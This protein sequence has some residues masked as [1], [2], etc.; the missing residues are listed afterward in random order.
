MIYNKLNVRDYLV[1]ND[2]IKMANDLMSDIGL[3]PLKNYIAKTNGTNIYD[4]NLNIVKFISDFILPYKT[5]AISKYCNY[6]GITLEC[7]FKDL[8]FVIVM[9]DYGKMNPFWQKYIKQIMNGNYLYTSHIRHEFNAFIVIYE[10][11]KKINPVTTFYDITHVL[12]PIFAHHGNL[13]ENFIKK[14]DFNGNFPKTPEC[15]NPLNENEFLNCIK[16]ISAKFELKENQ[17]WL[18]DWYRQEIFRYILSEGDKKSSSY[19]SNKRIL[20]PFNESFSFNDIFQGKYKNFQTEVL[21][22]ANNDV[23][24]VRAKTGGGKTFASLLWG[25]Y[26]IGNGYAERIVIAMPTQ[27]TSNSI[28][29][30]C[31]EFISDTNVYHGDVKNNLDSKF[32]RYFFLRHCMHLESSLTVLTIDQ[33]LYAITLYNDEY[34]TVA[35]NLAN[36]CLIIDEMDFYDSFVISNVIELIKFCRRFNVRI[37]IM[38]ATI[39]DKLINIIKDETNISYKLIDFSKGDYTPKTDIISISNWNDNIYDI[40]KNANNCIIYCNTIKSAIENYD[41]IKS[42]RND[43]VVYHSNM[44]S[45]DKINREK[46]IVSMLGKKA[47]NDKNAKGVVIMTQIGELSINISSDIIISE[48]APIDR[49]IQRFG[50]GCRF[51]EDICKAYIILPLND[52]NGGINYFPYV[53]KNGKDYIPN[54]YIS[55]TFD[56]LC[57]KTY[58]YGTFMEMINEIYLDFK[59]EE[60]DKFNSNKICEISKRNIFLNG[61]FNYEDIEDGFSMPLDWKSRDI[62]PN[63]RIYINDDAF[64]NHETN[65]SFNEF[66]VLKS[67]YSLTIRLKNYEK[68][69]K[70]IIH[71]EIV[72]EHKKFYIEI[73]PN[74]YY[75][76]TENNFKGLNI[77]YLIECCRTSAVFL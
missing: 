73:L 52:Y 24:F 29:I 2:L 23:I 70:L 57:E 10:K 77:N 1:S 71:K 34:K 11:Y 13:N 12:F 31:S 26:Q 75:F 20:M 42:F 33:L 7:F 54:K 25:N 30:D 40:V 64:L 28:S 38:S 59:I 46:K 65:Y 15:K 69:K 53:V 9:H 60:Y 49:L 43:V 14:Y 32:D 16:K 37:L 61:C 66:M 35:F 5:Y 27:F 67:K 50:R 39:P 17:S 51:N 18:N 4:H 68:I 3:L 41:I 48:L 45:E 55:R 62:E 63:I 47:W 22:Q 44:L 8:L 19:E 76:N 6:F 56:K 72:V 21:K 74:E 36:S 58:S